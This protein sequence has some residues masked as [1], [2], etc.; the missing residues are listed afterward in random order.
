MVALILMVRAT[1]SRVIFLPS[2]FGNITH[3]AIFL[4]LKRRYMDNPTELCATGKVKR[5]LEKVTRLHNMYSSLRSSLK[6]VR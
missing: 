1:N 6:S 4:S 3:W 2:L 5:E